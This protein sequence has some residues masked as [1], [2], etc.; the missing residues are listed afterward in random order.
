MHSYTVT[1]HYQKMIVFVFYHTV[2]CFLCVCFSS[3]FP[4]L[5][6]SVRCYHDLTVLPGLI[7]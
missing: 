7:L 3:F 1:R 6:A 5:L 2:L 4:F